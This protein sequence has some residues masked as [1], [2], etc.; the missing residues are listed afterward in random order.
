VGRKRKMIAKEYLGS[1]SKPAS[2][3]GE[4][5]ETSKP[6]AKKKS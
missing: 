4:L 2:E 1:K 3:G 5:A 6:R